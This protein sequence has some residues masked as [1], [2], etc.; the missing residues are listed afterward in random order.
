MPDPIVAPANLQWLGLA[1]E[2]TRG[3]PVA[4]PTIWVPVDSPT[5]VETPTLLSDNAL[6]GSMAGEYEQL[7]GQKFDTVTYKTF[8]Y[9]DSVF[10]HLLAVLGNPDAMSGTTDPWTHK[11]ALYNGA[12][13]DAAQP[14]SYTVFV[15]DAAG[16]VRQVPGCI[17]SSVKVTVKPDGLSELN[18]TWI[19]LPAAV[20]A[21]PVNTP[22]TAKPMP[23]WNSTITLGGTVL[24]QFSEV[25]LEYKRATEPV[26]SITGTQAPFA[27]FGGPVTVSGSLTAIY[28]GA[29]DVN[30]VNFLANTQ[31][32]LLVKVSP[33]GDVNHSITLQHSK[34]AYDASAPSGTNKWMEVKATIKA[35]ANTTDALGGGFSP[36]Q[37]ILTSPQS[38]AY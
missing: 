29:T 19:G 17:P 34:V 31:P 2:V 28:Q 35:L 15:N 9:V 13:G 38:T 21:S 25:D 1:K 37:A 24:S 12:G 10:P 27:I 5:W 18:V 30:M 7:Q 33:V 4:L 6:R 32:A 26:P 11:T 20:I 23:G 36:V 8:L 3:V 16:N 14:P 22:T